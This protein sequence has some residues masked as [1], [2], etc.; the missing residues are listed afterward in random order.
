M[1]E[2]SQNTQRNANKEE[3][4]QNTFFF[5]DLYSAKALYPKDVSHEVCIPKDLA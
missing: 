4:L 2:H 1:H 3:N 5:E